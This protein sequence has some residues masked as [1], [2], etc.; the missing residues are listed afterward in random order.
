M[1]FVFPN[2]K[3]YAQQY[4]QLVERLVNLDVDFKTS[5]FNSLLIVLIDAETYE[6]LH[7]NCYS[8]LTE[9]YKH[10]LN[11][12]SH[13]LMF[14]LVLSHYEYAQKLGLPLFKQHI[15]LE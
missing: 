3:K 14:K 5:L 4:N 11:D 8:L 9:N 10:Y 2:T 6:G 1:A 12:I 13:E 15:D 7:A